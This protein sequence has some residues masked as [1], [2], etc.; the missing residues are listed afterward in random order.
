[1]LAKERREGGREGAYRPLPSRGDG[2]P[3]PQPTPTTPT[4][5]HRHRRPPTHTQSLS[6]SPPSPSGSPR[7][8]PPL[9]LRAPSPP[10][11]SLLLSLSQSP[12]G[13]SRGAGCAMCLTHSHQEQGA[14]TELTLE[15]MLQYTCH[16]ENTP[17]PQSK[18][19]RGTKTKSMFAF[20]SSV[21]VICLVCQAST[22]HRNPVTQLDTFQIG[23]VGGGPYQGLLPCPFIRNHVTVVP[24]PKTTN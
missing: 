19:A 4:G 14:L 17:P 6:L 24:F 16:S 10:S 22:H 1:M 3:G 13:D 12:L 7:P 20:H 21:R 18:A 2:C 15:K 9:L 8:P 23:G 11:P 5:R